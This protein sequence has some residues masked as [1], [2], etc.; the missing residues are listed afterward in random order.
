MI[1]QLVG[2]AGALWFE[3]ASKRGWQWMFAEQTKCYFAESYADQATAPRIYQPRPTP[4]VISELFAASIADHVEAV[5]FDAEDY[6]WKARF[7][8]AC[9]GEALLSHIDRPVR[10]VL[11]PGGRIAIGIDAKL[12]PL[13]S[14]VLPL[15]FFGRVPAT[16]PA[17]ISADGTVA[18]ELPERPWLICVPGGMLKILVNGHAVVTHESGEF[19]IVGASDLEEIISDPGVSGTAQ[20]VVGGPAGA[21]VR[22]VLPFNA[23]AFNG[24]SIRIRG[25]AIS[26]IA[27]PRVLQ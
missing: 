13:E 26:S 24:G 10:L 14:R 9:G 17:E 6:S 18:F 25:D 8:D 7:R 1:Y 21:I 15:I 12:L 5:S 2:L 11:P 22:V 4:E 23:L 27:G 3:N 19:A 20:L 16:I